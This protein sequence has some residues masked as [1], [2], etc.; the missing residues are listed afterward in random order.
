[1]RLGRGLIALAVLFSSATIETCIYPTEH[2]AD[3]RVNITPVP[4]LIRGNDTEARARAWQMLAAGD[5]AEIANVS[6]VWTSAT[7]SIATVDAA[8]HIVGIKSGTTT[9]RAAAA[10]FDQRSQPGEATL[11]VADP[12][13][14]DS[15]RPQTVS[16]G[17]TVTLYGVGVDSIFQASLGNGLLIPNVVTRARDANGYARIT[18]WVPPPS[19]PDS[20]FYIGNGVFGFSRDTV[21]VLQRDLYEPNDIAPWTLDLDGPGPFPGTPFAF[22]RFLNPALA[23]EALLRDSVS[24]ADWYRL[25]QAT[26]RDLTIVLTAPEVR[27]TFAAYVS[28]GGPSAWTIGP[29]SHNC[30]GGKF[31]PKERLGDSTIVALAGVPAGT[32]DVYALYAQPGRYGL[33]VA[34]GYFTSD[35]LDRRI[36]RDAHEEDDYCDAPGAQVTQPLGYKATQTI[37]N[38]HD[39][40][41]IRFNVPSA[42]PVRIRTAALPAVAGKDTSD[43]DVYVLR[44]TASGAPLDSIGAYAHPLSTIDTTFGVVVGLPAGN[45][46]AVVVDFAGVSTPYAICIGNPGACANPFPV[47]PVPSPAQVQAAARRRAAVEA[48][49]RR[50]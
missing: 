23:F 43:I 17:E 39:V 24:G 40:D 18:Y 20:L 1:M 29:G 22:V 34:E 36:V 21:R 9:I 26:T 5:S 16:F 32:L 13:E 47:G 49:A 35:S 8:G 19:R 27:G 3:V 50:D 31:A 41:W 2:D 33:T 15:I 37:D 6:F 48:P 38:P 45:Y 14:I 12:L 25:Q 42:T 7:P 10:N 4:I 46:F 44:D 11:R 28:N 30:R